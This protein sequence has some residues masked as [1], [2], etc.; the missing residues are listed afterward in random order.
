MCPT[1]TSWQT[2]QICRL[3]SPPGV[4]KENLG[5]RFSTWVQKVPWLYPIQQSLPVSYI[6]Q[7]DRHL[8]SRSTSAPKS[9]A[10][11]KYRC[12][13]AVCSI[14]ER[15]IPFEIYGITLTMSLDWSY[16]HKCMADDL[17]HTLSSRRQ[18]PNT[19]HSLPAQTD[20]P[21]EP[22]LATSYH[23]SHWDQVLRRYSPWAAAPSCPCSA[24]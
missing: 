14:H 9:L 13:R 18:T 8:Q 24:W 17:T 23:P 2:L 21:W 10:E 11:R 5:N 6:S 4:R 12:S 15:H 7:A 19:S 20:S 22:P 3:G 16:Q 1:H